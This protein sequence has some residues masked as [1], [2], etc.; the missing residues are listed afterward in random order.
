MQKAYQQYCENVK[1]IK[2]NPQNFKKII[3]PQYS[4][5]Q[6]AY[7]LDRDLIDFMTPKWHA[8]WRFVNALVKEHVYCF[9]KVTVPDE[10]DEDCVECVINSYSN[11]W[12]YF[13]KLCLTGAFQISYVKSHY[14]IPDYFMTNMSDE[15]ADLV[16]K[17]L[18]YEV[19]DYSSDYHFII[20]DKSN[21]NMTI[22]LT[23]SQICS[24][25]ALVQR[26]FQL[27]PDFRFVIDEMR[28]RYFAMECALYKFPKDI[29]KLGV[30]NHT[31][32][33]MLIRDFSPNLLSCLSVKRLDRMELVVKHWKLCDLNFDLFTDDDRDYVISYMYDKFH[34]TGL[35]ETD[36]KYHKYC[37]QFASKFEPIMQYS[38]IH[39]RMLLQHKAKDHAYMHNSMLQIVQK[40]SNGKK[41]FKLIK[42]TFKKY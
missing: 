34:L 17:T 30:L 9:V 13:P 37:Y 1:L 36:D 41:V 3:D 2:E 11:C 27:H 8:T 21:L 7:S 32:I 28:D 16:V 6:L 25:R 33:D 12:L 14:D 42:I 35:T 31:K 19:S 23:I 20:K 38:P 29:S 5:C 10:L 24:S 26:M 15:L 18:Y 4:L 22:D 40:M 39:Y